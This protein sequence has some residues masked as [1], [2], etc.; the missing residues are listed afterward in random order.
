MQLPRRLL[1][2]EVTILSAKSWTTN[3]L[4]NYISEVAKKAEAN[5][6]ACKCRLHQF[7]CATSQ[8]NRRGTLKISD[9][10]CGQG[11]CKSKTSSV[12]HLWSR[13]ITAY[14]AAFAFLDLTIFSCVFSGFLLSSVPQ[15]WHSLNLAV[16]CVFSV[17]SRTVPY[18]F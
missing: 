10:P 17:A 12:S 9:Y 18:P 3:C 16:G 8:S 5:L 7:C 11:N 14:L 15:T 1:G 2:D 13:R 4:F 6:E